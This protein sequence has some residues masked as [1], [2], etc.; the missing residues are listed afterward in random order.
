[1]GTA[2][3]V[4]AP[5][6]SPL[7]ARV[8]TLSGHC[9]Q[10]PVRNSEQRA[11]SI[12]QRIEP[13]QKRGRSLSVAGG[14][15]LRLGTLVTRRLWF[16]ALPLTCSPALSQDPCQIKDSKEGSSDFPGPAPKTAGLGA[17]VMSPLYPQAQS[18]G[19]GAPRACY[20]NQ[21]EVG[22]VSPPRNFASERHKVRAAKPAEQM[23]P[24]SWT[25]SAA[26]VLPGPRFQP[27][28]VA[29]FRS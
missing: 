9:Q 23:S 1:M 22:G 5:F 29:G 21:A 18:L 26:G 28:E 8:A 3:S 11:L 12:Q 17:G 27:Q 25:L 24:N 7:Q 13:E 2:F 19:R 6:A 15:V 14:S 20:G 16:L 4:A 10:L